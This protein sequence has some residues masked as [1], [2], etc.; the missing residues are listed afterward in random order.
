MPVS[1]WLRGWNRDIRVHYRLNRNLT[2]HPI[3]DSKRDVTRGCVSPFNL[4]RS[5]IVED[6]R[7]SYY[8]P[9]W[10]I[11]LFHMFKPGAGCPLVVD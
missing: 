2:V 10:C 3:H 7:C 8:S 11:L 9:D 5:T 4:G 6:Q 1:G